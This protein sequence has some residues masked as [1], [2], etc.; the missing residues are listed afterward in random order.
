M[1]E[2][3]TTQIMEKLS[4]LHAAVEATHDLLCE[5]HHHTDPSVPRKLVTLAT[6]VAEEGVS[7]EPNPQSLFGEMAVTNGDEPEEKQWR[8]LSLFPT[9]VTGESSP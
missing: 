2:P 3:T 9:G 4:E 1:T 8:Q 6:T 5:V 7:K